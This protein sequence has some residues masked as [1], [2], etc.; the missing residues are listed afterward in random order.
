MF[1]NCLKSFKWLKS[2]DLPKVANSYLPKD[3]SNPCL[4]AISTDIS[5]PLSTSPLYLDIAFTNLLGKLFIHSKF[6]KGS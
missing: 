5:S 6:L 3:I 4:T 1:I 2:L